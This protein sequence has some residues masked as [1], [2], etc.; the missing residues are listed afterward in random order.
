MNPFSKRDNLKEALI[1]KGIDEDRQKQQ[2]A[3]RGS[4]QLQ[5]EK[6]NHYR[7]DLLQQIDERRLKEHALKDSEL[8][9]KE[10]YQKSSKAPDEL[11]RYQKE[12]HREE[13]EKY[14]EDLDLMTRGATGQSGVQLR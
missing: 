8:R 2:L 13:M 11:Q 10:A 7:N 12:R 1:A 3:E 5:A 6:R 4:R 14:R 9:E